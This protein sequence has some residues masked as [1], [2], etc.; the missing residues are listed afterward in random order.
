MP[1]YTADVSHVF[2]NDCRWSAYVITPLFTY[3]VIRL[4]NGYT[5]FQQTSHFKFE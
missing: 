1:S 3:K 2:Y 4:Q 5:R